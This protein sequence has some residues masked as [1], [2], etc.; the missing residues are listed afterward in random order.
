M[1]DAFLGF[2][3]T[4]AVGGAVIGIY[5]TW[6]VRKQ[7]P[8]VEHVGPLEYDELLLEF[9]AW[10]GDEAMIEATLLEYINTRPWLPK[11]FKR[12]L[13]TSYVAEW[14]CVEGIQIKENDWISHG[15]IPI[16]DGMY[17]RMEL[18]RKMHDFIREERAGYQQTYDSVS[19]AVDTMTLDLIALNEDS[20]KFKE[21]QTDLR[22]FGKD[23]EKA[24]KIF[25]DLGD[26]LEPTDGPDMIIVAD[27]ETR[28]ADFKSSDEIKSKYTPEELAQ[29]AINR[30]KEGT[31]D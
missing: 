7:G 24:S 23:G 12:H 1:F 5:K 15:F 4:L 27:G 30:D 8:S 9:N 25:R 21:L 28:I 11:F 14:Y 29:Q 19:D 26:R 10:P 17:W 18:D 31:D 16:E 20:P 6:L 13:F 22:Y 3:I 2:F